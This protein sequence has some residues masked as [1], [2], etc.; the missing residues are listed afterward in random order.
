[1]SEL[2]LDDPTALYVQ[3]QRVLAHEI[4]A[5][6]Y[7]P[8]AQLPTHRQLCA[9]F[10]V[11]HITVRDAVR[12]LVHEGLAVTRQGAGTFA[13]GTVRSADAVALVPGWFMLNTLHG[14]LAPEDSR[15]RTCRDDRGR[16]VAG[17]CWTYQQLEP[18]LDPGDALD[19]ARLTRR[20][21]CATATR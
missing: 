21:P 16:P 14:P 15:C 13:S 11:S 5:G 10:G 2:D 6:V 3:I 1:M 18:L 12:A 9:R 17:P 8:G 20:R 7:E 19:P 4:A